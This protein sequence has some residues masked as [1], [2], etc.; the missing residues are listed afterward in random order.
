VDEIEDP[1]DAGKNPEM[2][3]LK[4]QWREFLEKVGTQKKALQGILS[5]T[6]PKNL[7]EGTLVLVCKGPFHQEQLSKPENKTLV[8][9]ILKEQ[10][11]R[12]ITLVPVLPEGTPM[13][14][15]PSG[16][17]APKPL[18]APKVDLKELEK[19]EPLVAAALKMFGG[20]IVEVKR[21]NPQK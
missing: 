8:E 12:P 16:P 20:K 10:L 13:P 5:D 17:R 18:S 7:D 14:E 15:K 9:Q 11:G 4:S 19:E 3:K 2:A 21:N 6:H 1:I